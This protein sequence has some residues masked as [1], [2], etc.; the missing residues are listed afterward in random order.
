MSTLGTADRRLAWKILA[1]IRGNSNC[2]QHLFSDMTSVRP[3][4]FLCDSLSP[5]PTCSTVRRAHMKATI[6]AQEMGEDADNVGHLSH[7]AL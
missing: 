6:M 1:Q 2:Y 3:I 4:R 7:H 5:V